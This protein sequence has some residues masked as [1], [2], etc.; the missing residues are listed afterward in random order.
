MSVDAWL[1]WR[2]GQAEQPAPV[3]APK[4]RLAADF[5]VDPG[6]ALDHLE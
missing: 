6:M 2:R 4:L 3:Q 1:A 5:T